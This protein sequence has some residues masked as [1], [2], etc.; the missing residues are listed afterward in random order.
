MVLMFLQTQSRNFV[1]KDSYHGAP[2]SSSGWLPVVQPLSMKFRDWCKISAQLNILF[3]QICII[4]L[5]F[6]H[7]QSRNF[8]DKGCMFEISL[9]VR[10]TA[11]LYM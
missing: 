6:L 10:I 4:F 11:C 8:M 5:I 1:D 3:L 2:F 7:T 9:T